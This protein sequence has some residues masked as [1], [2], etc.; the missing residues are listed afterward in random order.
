MTF[1]NMTPHK[2]FY[3]MPDG[4]R[5]SLLPSGE[6]ARVDEILTGVAKEVG[7]GGINFLVKTSPVNGEVYVTKE[8]SD[9][10]MPFPEQDGQTI[11]IVSTMVKDQILI[12]QARPDVWAPGTGPKDGPIREDGKIVAV[13]R[14]VS[15]VA[16]E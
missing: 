3:Q 12:G 8:G 15:A 14:F 5:V 2:L 1:M 16:S 10:K 9:E 11:F 6:V 13:T 7:V 4:S